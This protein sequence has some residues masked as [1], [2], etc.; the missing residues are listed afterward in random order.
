MKGPPAKNDEGARNDEGA[1]KAE[2]ARNNEGAPGKSGRELAFQEGS[3]N[4]KEEDEVMRGYYRGA[5]LI[6]KRPP[7]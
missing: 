3:E 7:P 4:K 2:G 6:R 5:S 1:Q